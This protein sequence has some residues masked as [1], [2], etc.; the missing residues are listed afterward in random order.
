MKETIKAVLILLIVFGGILFCIS[1]IIHLALT[2]S[3][4]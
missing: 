3:S 1:R 4:F 2:G